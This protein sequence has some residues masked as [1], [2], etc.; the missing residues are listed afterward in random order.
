MA[1]SSTASLQEALTEEMSYRDFLVSTLQ[2]G[3]G[4]GIHL[5][6]TDPKGTNEHISQLSQTIDSLKEQLVRATELER[7]ALPIHQLGQ[8]AEH[9]SSL[10]VAVA[11]AV[12]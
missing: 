4:E 9:G 8:P 11:F 10:L 3:T 7:A 12:F 5:V 2:P 6:T 1:M